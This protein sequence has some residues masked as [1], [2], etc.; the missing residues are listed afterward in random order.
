[1]QRQ[2]AILTDDDILAIYNFILY[3]KHDEINDIM[4]KLEYIKDMILLE[5]KFR[6]D[7][8]VLN[9]EY[10]KKLEEKQKEEKED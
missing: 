8:N 2:A 5:K 3:V 7:T 1:M 6:E 4:E 10:Y 9:N